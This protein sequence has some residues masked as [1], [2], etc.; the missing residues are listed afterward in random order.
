M[1]NKFVFIRLYAGLNF[2]LPKK[3][4]Q[5]LIQL[6]LNGNPSVKDVIESVGVPHTE[7]ELVLIN[8]CLTVL[9]QQV[10]ENDRI[11]VYPFFYQLEIANSEKSAIKMPDKI[12]FILDV[13]LGKL[14]NMLR[15]LGFDCYYRNNLDDDE[16]ID[17]AYNEERIILSRDLGIFKNNKV[18]YGY[19][20]RSQDP[21][22]QLKEILERYNLKTKI[23]PL[24]RC[25]KCNGDIQIIE[26]EKII[27]GLEE[28]TKLF[29]NEFYICNNCKKTYWK[30]SHYDKIIEFVENINNN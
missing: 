11:S 12:K 9:D 23:K 17:I 19:F 10:K 15:I 21:K 18:K 29:F 16:I 7:I 26:K 8:N 5:R 4:R 3:F 30:G 13:H 27:D 28:K 1:M 24:S 6:K 2:F 20:P 25:I 22:I 14:N